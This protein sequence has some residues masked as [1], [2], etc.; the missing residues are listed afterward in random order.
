MDETENKENNNFEI[1]E[2]VNELNKVKEELKES[3]EINRKLVNSIKNKDNLLTEEKE[4]PETLES[5]VDS[6]ITKYILKGD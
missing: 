5:F 1:E 6:M 4:E 3:R 2:L